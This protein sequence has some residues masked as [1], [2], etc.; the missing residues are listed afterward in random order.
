MPETL[1]SMLHAYL[2]GALTGAALKAFEKRL[3]EPKVAARLKDLQA[4]RAAMS[5]SAPQP[6]SEQSKRMWAAIRAQAQAQAVPA[7]VTAPLS[8]EEPWYAFLTKPW[9][10]GFSVGLVGAAAALAIVL[11]IQ[12]SKQALPPASE[13]MQA[14]VAPAANEMASADAAAKPAREEASDTRAMLASVPPTAKKASR[15]IETAAPAAAAVRAERSRK[16]PTEVERALADNQVDD[17]I[18]AFLQ[19]RQAQPG[20]SLAM[21]PAAKNRSAFGSPA[22]GATLAGYSNAPAAEMEAVDSMAMRAVQ[23]GPDR[24]GFWDWHPAAIALNQRN[25]SQARMEL[26]SASTRAGEPVERA[27]AASALTLLAAPGGPLEGTQPLLP[28]PGDLR[29]LGA[30]RWQLQVDAR[31][32]RYSAGVSARLPGF[33]VEGDSLLLDLTFD[34]ATFSPGT[35]FTRV[36]GEAPAKVYDAASQSVDSGQFSAPAGAVYN[37]KDRELRLR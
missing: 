21:A 28:S 10:R 4:L 36:A 9:T 2:D 11:L 7:E 24:N 6:T 22:G 35:R 3:A 34:R 25:W 33:R 15:F 30:G 31:L 19:A 5:A 37:V 18:D 12:P 20:A 27:F 23:G 13:A 16:E 8:S 17:L 14:P 29:V 32:A 26:E 1:E